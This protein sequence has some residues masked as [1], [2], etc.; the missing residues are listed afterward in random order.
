MDD[1]ERAIDPAM[2]TVVVRGGLELRLGIYLLLKLF[3]TPR[4][5][6]LRRGLRLG[7][8]DFRQI[9][10]PVVVSWTRSSLAFLEQA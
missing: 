3:S 9:G 7:S 1:L 5:T 4:I 6:N 10:Q 2:E 8:A